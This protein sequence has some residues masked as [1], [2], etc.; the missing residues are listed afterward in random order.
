MKNKMYLQLFAEDGGDSS[1]EGTKPGAGG[2]EPSGGDPTENDPD[3]EGEKKYTDADLDEIINRKFAKWQKEQQK[4][5]DEAAKLAEMNATEKAKYEKEKLESELNEYKRKDSIAKM[6]KTARNMLAESNISV[7]DDLL[8]MLVSTDAEETKAAVE[9]FS[10]SFTK[11]LESAVKERL[12]G[13]PPKRGSGGA[14]KMSKAD[15]MAIKDPDLRQEKM[16][17]NRELFNF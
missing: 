15:I 12:K 14:A 9:A 4:K 6:T 16:L 8:S 10:E 2:T 1:G 3:G 13:E 7:P 11:A 5:T 17:E